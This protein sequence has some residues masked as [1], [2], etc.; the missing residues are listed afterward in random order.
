MPMN[1]KSSI[2][3]FQKVSRKNKEGGSKFMALNYTLRFDNIRY[4]PSTSDVTN[5]PESH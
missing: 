4:V 5:P 2:Q 1:E 3:Y